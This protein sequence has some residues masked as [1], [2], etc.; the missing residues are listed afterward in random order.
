MINILT[1]KLIDD[2]NGKEINR[3]IEERNLLQDLLLKK[4]R[5]SSHKLNKS[6]RNVQ[7]GNSK[8]RRR[9]K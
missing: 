1:A 7:S 2:G 3:I 9:K 5:I 4:E 6:I 8:K